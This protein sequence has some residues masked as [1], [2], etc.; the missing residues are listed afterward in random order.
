MK[1]R[2]PRAYRFTDEDIEIL[3]KLQKLT[4]LSAS[5]A[6]RIAIREALTARETKRR[7]K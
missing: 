5:A 2:H 3:E 1:E 4:G 6:I 7:K